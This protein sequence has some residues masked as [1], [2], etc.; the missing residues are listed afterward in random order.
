MR[1]WR[2]GR[3]RCIGVEDGSNVI[4]WG[5]VSND[6]LSWM[7]LLRVLWVIETRSTL[8]WE[9]VSICHLNPPR[10]ERAAALAPNRERRPWRRVET[11][12]GLC[13]GFGERGSDLSSLAHRSA[14]GGVRASTKIE[15]QRM[16][17]QPGL[18]R[19]QE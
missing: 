16:R 1:V 19:F 10:I 17:P 8:L 12:G 14:E 4:G 6:L 2:P 18:W 11:L 13:R 5:A 3:R 7:M 9:S 15:A